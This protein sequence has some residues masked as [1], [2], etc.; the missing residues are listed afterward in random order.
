[1]LDQ[2][3][4][5][6]CGFIFNLLAE[7][8]KKKLW[9]FLL[10]DEVE[11]KKGHKRLGRQA[12]W[13]MENKRNASPRNPCFLSS[14]FRCQVY[15]LF[16]GDTFLW[17]TSFDS[18]YRDRLSRLFLAEKMH[19]FDRNQRLYCDLRISFPRLSRLQLKK[20]KKQTW[21]RI[22]FPPS[23]HNWP[24]TYSHQTPFNAMFH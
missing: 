16:F 12:S 9:S 22:D 17:T 3:S 8:R 10:V 1:M 14:D 13:I 20:G 6:V 24:H 19:D 18:Q 7:K 15:L 11:R 5:Q 4:P 2:L 23:F 21:K